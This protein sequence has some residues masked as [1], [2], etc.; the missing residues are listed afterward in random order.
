MQIKQKSK[1]FY[2]IFKC[3][4][5]LSGLS[6]KYLGINWGRQLF[7]GIYSQVFGTGIIG[8]GTGAAA[9]PGKTA[10]FFLDMGLLWANFYAST[11]VGVPFIS[12]GI[13]DKYP[14]NTVGKIDRDSEIQ[15]KIK[16][17]REN[18]TGEIY[19]KSKLMMK[20][21]FREPE[22][23]QKA[24]EDGWFKTGDIGYVNKHNYLH[25][26]GRKKETI[27]LHNGKK[28]APTDIEAFYQS[29][30]DGVNIAVC[31][32]HN[33]SGFDEIHMFIE[34]G[35]TVKQ[36]AEKA[37]E[38]ILSLSRSQ[39][40]LYKIN[41]FHFIEKIPVTSV[42]K[43]KRYI[44]QEFVNIPE[45]KTEVKTEVSIE[46]TVKNI[47][48]KISKHKENISLSASLRNELDMDSLSLFELAAELESLYGKDVCSSLDN[49]DTVND[50]V[51][52]ISNTNLQIKPSEIDMSD[53][54]IAK[55]PKD[56]KCMMLSKSVWRFNVKGIENIPTNENYILC[57]NHQSHF[58]SLWIWAA[59]GTDRIDAEKICCLAKK[60][61]L[62]NTVSKRWVRMLGAIPVDRSGNSASAMK[63]AL[64]CINSGY[65]I[66]IHPEGT[67][68][69]TGKLGTFRNG[70]AK[71]AIDSGKKII[72]V[73]IG[74]AFEIFPYNKAIPQIL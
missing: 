72:P 11:E 4:L 71:L 49:I 53:F 26:T 69:K 50:L 3:F 48:Q 66:L 10:K 28:V 73:Y 59:I 19:A 51:L 61:H 45:N 31:G 13:L 57:P 56:I 43:V 54:P 60:E 30:A 24:F 8:V 40:C 22:L 65:S 9:C 68:T 2:Y 12:A 58:D 42:G 27:L 39:D 16:N 32:I 63:R 1:I 41:D 70:A 6:R 37:K 7:K 23:T 33:K 52:Y 15:V 20:G 25:I 46:N 55:T 64:Q 44:L 14:Y 29:A 21:Y 62:D 34:T 35:T 18:G 67:R 17:P 5:A 38:T 74:G 36:K 47:I